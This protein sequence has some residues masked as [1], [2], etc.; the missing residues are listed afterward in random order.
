MGGS[1]VSYYYLMVT[2]NHNM[3][4][5]DT[6]VITGQ[7]EPWREVIRSL[8]PTV[9]PPSLIFSDIFYLFDFCDSICEIAR[10]VRI[11]RIF[12]SAFSFSSQLNIEHNDD[13]DDALLLLLHRTPPSPHFM[14]MGTPSRNDAIAIF[15]ISPVDEHVE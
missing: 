14:G 10:S 15:A 1:V 9:S 5:N 4:N 7:R 8:S 6:V 11:R 3:C 2:T 12:S 13:D